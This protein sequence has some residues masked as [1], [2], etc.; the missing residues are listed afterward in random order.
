[1]NINATKARLS[2]LL[3]QISLQWEQTR[4]TWTDEKAREFHERYMT[5]L[6]AEAEKALTAMDRLEVLAKK[7]KE[8]C[9]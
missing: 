5:T 9:E 6:M 4:S 7:V 1:M 3:K 8:D 2:G